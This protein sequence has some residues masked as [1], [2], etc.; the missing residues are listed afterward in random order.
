MS[1]KLLPTA[2]KELKKHRVVSMALGPTHSAVL[3]SSGCVYAFGRNVEGQLGTGNLATSSVATVLQ[4]KPFVSVC[5]SVCVCV[6][7]CVCVYV[8]VHMC[9]QVCKYMLANVNRS[10]YV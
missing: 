5:V 3:V 4:E 10:M 9:S 1:H 2:I 7:V 8:C 6:C